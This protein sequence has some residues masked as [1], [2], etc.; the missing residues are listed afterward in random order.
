MTSFEG[1]LGNVTRQYYSGCI[2]SSPRKCH[3]RSV[4]QLTETNQ[5]ESKASPPSRQHHQHLHLPHE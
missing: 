1:Y 5:L 4:V 3:V 2:I